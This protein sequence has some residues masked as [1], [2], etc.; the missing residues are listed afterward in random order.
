MDVSYRTKAITTKHLTKNVGVIEVP[1][2][3]MVTEIREGTVA[4]NDIMV[5]GIFPAFGQET[6]IPNA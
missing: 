6:V 4:L 5:M 2:W 3:D 1:V